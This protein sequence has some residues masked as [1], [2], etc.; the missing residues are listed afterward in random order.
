MTADK[1]NIVIN[2]SNYNKHNLHGLPHTSQGIT[3]YEL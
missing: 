2:D 3:V 1:R